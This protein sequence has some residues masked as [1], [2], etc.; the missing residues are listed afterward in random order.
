MNNIDRI[1][2]GTFVS[3]L[4]RRSPGPIVRYAPLEEMI[5]VTCRKCGAVFITKNIAYIGLSKVYYGD[6]YDKC[7]ECSDAGHSIRYLR[8]DKGRY[9]KGKRK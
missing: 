4:F 9:K 8:P 2:E 6:D 3:F 1:I 5:P 7:K